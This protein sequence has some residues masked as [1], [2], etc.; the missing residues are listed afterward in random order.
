VVY[1]LSWFYSLTY[2]WKKRSARVFKVIV[3][4]SY[5][6]NQ[7]LFGSQ[8]KTPLM[9]HLFF[10]PS[11][12]VWTCCLL[13]TC[14]LTLWRLLVSFLISKMQSLFSVGRRDLFLCC[15]VL[16]YLLER[17]GNAISTKLSQQIKNQTDKKQESK[18]HFLNPYQP[19]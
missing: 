1:F 6:Q 9:V 11:R 16:G 18:E 12:L 8:V 3:K 17:L 2:D 14:W 15:A 19:F 4:R 10:F 7:L 13:V 5:M